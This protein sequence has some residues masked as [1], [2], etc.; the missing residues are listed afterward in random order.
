[1]TNNSNKKQLACAVQTLDRLFYEKGNHQRCH[2]QVWRQHGYSIF[3]VSYPTYMKWLKIDVRGI[4]DLKPA[5]RKAL[6]H[7]DR[8][9]N[10]ISGE[11]YSRM[12]KKT[13]R[14]ER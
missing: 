12:N 7:L 11:K 6:H 2:K 8:T 4:P 9:M 13:E 5:T 14:K 10:D 3:G 1:M